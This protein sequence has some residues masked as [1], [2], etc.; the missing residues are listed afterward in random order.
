MFIIKHEAIQNY[1]IRL[2]SEADTYKTEMFFNKQKIR[3]ARTKDRKK[4]ER[5][6]YYYRKLIETETALKF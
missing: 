2:S 5:E 4:A 6:F 1:I 3:S